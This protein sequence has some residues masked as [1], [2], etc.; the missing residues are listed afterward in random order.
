MRASPRA[1]HPSYWLG[2]P[3]PYLQL[4]LVP[5]RT[6][7]RSTRRSHFISAIAAY[8]VNIG[9]LAEDV[10]S[11][12]RSGGTMTLIRGAVSILDCGTDVL[13][14]AAEAIEL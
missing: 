8:V 14:I 11:I 4:S 13:G 12:A 3:N 7:L 1:A 5:D 9:L 10:R 2:E 6:G